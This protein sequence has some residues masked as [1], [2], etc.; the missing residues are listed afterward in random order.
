MLQQMRALSKSW[1]STVFMGALALS[2]AVWGIADIFRGGSNDNDVVTVG[3]TAVSGP[4]FARDYRNFVRDQSAQLRRQITTDE[5]RKMGLG[6]IALDRV[7]NRAALDNIVHELGLA[8]SDADV[9]A[10]IRTM[11]AFNGP[12]GTFD[13]ATFERVMAQQGFS[14][15]E[16]IAGIRGDMEREQLLGPVE[17]GFQ[18]PLGYTRALF[19][20]FTERRAVQYVVLSAAS[21]PTIPAPSD[22]QLEAFVKAHEARFS[23]PE[24]RD[25]SYLEI[26]PEDVTPSLKVSDE[27]LHQAYDA[28]K[29][30]YIVPEKRDVEQIA[31][32]DEATAKAARAK[33]DGGLSFADVAKLQG[34]V[35]DNLST[36]V[37][38]DLGDRGAAVFALPAN[39][40]TAPL[41]NFSGWV[42]M[43][44]TKIT[45][46]VS[47]SFDDVKEDIRKDLLKQMAQAKIVDMT[48]AFTDAVS[49]GASL[50]EVAK[51]TGMHFGRVPAVDA[52]GL[53]PD[54]SRAAFPPDADLLKQ[55]FAADVGETGDP[56]SLKDGHTYA[57]NVAGV[58]PPKL[59]PL[60]AV[61]EDAIR[62]WLAMQNGRQL[63]LVAATL[64]GE[65]HKVGNLTA[66]A[67]KIGAPVQSG[68]ALSRQD[69]TGELFSPQLVNMIFREPPG[70]IAY[71]P[72]TN[73]AGM[74]IAQIT[75]ISHP[76]IPADSPIIQRGFQQITGQFEEDILLSLAKAGRDK[77]GVKINQKLVDQTIGG[78]GGS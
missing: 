29:S 31:F 9:S 42:L 74:V 15:D 36:V 59:K 67:Q 40:V 73:R 56:F 20:Y 78:E 32:R 33:I 53:A 71:G 43:H 3:P 46:G 47:K 77:Q 48:N 66:V 65:A 63:Q 30:T 41:K 72:T 25:V 58:T 7:I 34:T 75:G 11:G 19:A 14:E 39:G 52:Q 1:V 44:V 37:Q 70:G 54:G 27:Q 49:S 69:T 24:Y 64:A 22:A 12:L 55:I 5:A 51:K 10:N 23:T 35:V 4:V 21:L 2:F 6:Q 45:P 16:F 13:R 38:A 62:V 18:V 28:A 17:A 8:V 60:S 61:R 68:P 76:Q 26:G 57:I 50:Q